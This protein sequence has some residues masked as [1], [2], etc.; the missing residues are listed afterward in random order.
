MTTHLR[1]QPEVARGVIMAA[2]ASPLSDTRT[3][4]TMNLNR[5]DLNLLVALDVL[6][7]ERS[8]THAA[9]RLNLSPSATSGALARLRLYFDD[10]L[11]TQIGRRMMPT[12]LGESLQASVRD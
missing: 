4:H 5:L 3:G 12:P 10:E 6:L 7:C 1:S 11:L 8:I 2:T 9:E